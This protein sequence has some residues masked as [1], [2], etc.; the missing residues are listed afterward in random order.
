MHEQP[1]FQSAA[2]G[3]ELLGVSVQE[4]SR[5]VSFCPAEMSDERLDSYERACRIQQ[6]ARDIR[7]GK[8]KTRPLGEFMDELGIR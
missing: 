2:E 1:V 6:E 5:P 8:V 7:A 4:P 3:Q